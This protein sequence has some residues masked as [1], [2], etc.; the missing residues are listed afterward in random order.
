MY[1]YTYIYIYIYSLSN[2]GMTNEGGG[3]EMRNGWV[4]MEAGGREGRVGGF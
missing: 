4:G 1:V 2:K 3:E